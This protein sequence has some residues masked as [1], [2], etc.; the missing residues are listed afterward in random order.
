MIGCS[1]TMPAAPRMSRAWRAA[2]RAL[3]TVFIFALAPPE[4]QAQELGLGDL[5]D[6]LDELL[7]DELER[8]DGLAELDG[9]LR[10]LEAPVVA[11]H[12]RPDRPPRDAVARLGQAG[13]RALQAPDAGQ[14]VLGRD[15]AV[16][17]RQLR[18]DRRA[19]RELAVDVEG[20]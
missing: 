17:E 13:E 15:A 11:A 6:H 5:G 19:H 20:A 7:L 9:R 1:S 4:L 14:L 18:G 3:R 2:S 16:G 10:V 8:P 12:R